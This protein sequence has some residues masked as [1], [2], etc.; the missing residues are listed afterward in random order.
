MSSPFSPVSP[1]GTPGWGIVSSSFNT[2]SPFPFVSA[3]YDEVG[4]DEGGYGEDGYDTPSTPA[5][6][7]PTPAW[8]V[9]TTK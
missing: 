5:F 1:T 3:A 4:Y 8:A 7:I 2:W 6:S 9:E